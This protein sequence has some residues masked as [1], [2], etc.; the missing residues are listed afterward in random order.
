MQWTATK[1]KKIYR[2]GVLKKGVKN[3]EISKLCG[4]STLIPICPALA[5]F[6]E[7]L[8]RLSP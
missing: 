8:K 2:S 5:P 1:T 6:R 4:Q 7:G 3:R